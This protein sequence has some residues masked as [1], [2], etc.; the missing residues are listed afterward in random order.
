MPTRK[1]I[2]DY[3]ES[4]LLAEICNRCPVCGFFEKTTENFTNHHINHDSTISE[5]WNLIRICKTCHEEINKNKEDGI[6]DRK[7][8]QIKKDL[9]RKLVGTASYEVLLLANGSRTTTSLPCLA[10]PLIKLSLIK[11]TGSGIHCCRSSHPTIMGYKITEKG[12]ELIQ[13]LNLK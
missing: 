4:L 13:K 2:S 10:N 11:E 9:F 3:I 5:Y 8:K 7:I 1:P 12:K 6:R